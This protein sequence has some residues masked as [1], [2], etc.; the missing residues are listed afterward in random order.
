MPGGGGGGGI[1]SG[2][3]NDMAGGYKGENQ[4]HE[5]SEETVIFKRTIGG[6]PMIMEGIIDGGG[7]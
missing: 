5:K 6:M 7:I 2:T 4:Q 3:P 1:M